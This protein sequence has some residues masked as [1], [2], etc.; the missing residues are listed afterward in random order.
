M[1]IV[2]TMVNLEEI[3]LSLTVVSQ[4]LVVEVA[5]AKETEMTQQ[6]QVVQVEQNKE[7]MTLVVMAVT[8]VVAMV[9]VAAALVVAVVVLALR[10]HRPAEVLQQSLRVAHD[11]VHLRGGLAGEQQGRPGHGLHRLEGLRCCVPWT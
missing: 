3:H 1:D 5:E 9:A 7:L 6:V 8:A 2:V 11:A 10:L 4:L